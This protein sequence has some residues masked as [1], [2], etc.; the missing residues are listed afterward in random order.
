MAQE[1]DLLPRLNTSMS[2]MYPI[3][4]RRE[5]QTHIVLLHL[6]VHTI[7]EEVGLRIERSVCF[8]ILRRLGIWRVPA[9]S[10]VGRHIKL[11]F[12][13]V[14]FGDPGEEELHLRVEDWLVQQCQ[15]PITR[16]QQGK[17]SGGETPLTHIRGNHHRCPPSRSP[18]GPAPGP[19]PL[20]GSRGAASP[21]CRRR[22]ASPPAELGERARCSA[23]SVTYSISQALP[24][25]PYRQYAQGLELGEG[26]MRT[27]PTGSK[28]T[29]LTLLILLPSS[30]S[31]TCSTSSSLPSGRSL[32]FIEDFM[33]LAPVLAGVT[34]WLSIP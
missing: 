32:F 30:S 24:S 25:Y 9:A 1:T 4:W 23:L 33:G 22:H 2:A 10:F 34:S 17:L 7:R 6:P 11:P 12:P 19:A 31:S 18:S 21:Y 15:Q 13:L 28:A 16:A 5:L 26:G 14:D 3:V 27:A 29:F 8:T 20:R